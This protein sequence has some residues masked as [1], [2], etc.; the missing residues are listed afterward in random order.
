MRTEIVAKRALKALYEKIIGHNARKGLK[1]FIHNG[2]RG[3]EFYHNL[4]KGFQKIA[5]IVGVIPSDIAVLYCLWGLP[6]LEVL[7]LSLLSPAQVEAMLS[8][9]GKHDAEILYPPQMGKAQSENYI[10]AALHESPGAW[11]ALARHSASSV[12]PIHRATSGA[13][14]VASVMA[15]S[16]SASSAPS[17]GFKR[18]SA[19]AGLRISAGAGASASASADADEA[20]VVLNA[21]ERRMVGAAFRAFRDNVSGDDFSEASPSREASL[22]SSPLSQPR[23]SPSSL[24]LL[25]IRETAAKRPRIDKE[26]EE[27]S[28]SSCSPSSSPAMS[29]SIQALIAYRASA[30]VSMLVDSATSTSA[31]FPSPHLS[32]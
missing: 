4:P 15:E 29:S 20:E 11:S 16:S 9:K 17:V 26:P 23:M 14:G 12:R 7:D 32:C 31:G 21:R 24:L 13:K 5:V 30:A 22:S 8:R 18:T 28:A 1:T 3:S 6:N 10:S 2:A 25:E 27:A 19:R